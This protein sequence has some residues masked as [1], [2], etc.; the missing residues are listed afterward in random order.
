MGPEPELAAVEGTKNTTQHNLNLAIIQHAIPK[1]CNAKSLDINK[2]T[3]ETDIHQAFL[4]FK[5]LS[6]IF[7]MEMI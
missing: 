2:F 7:L 5:K 1:N 4:S 3:N 6:C